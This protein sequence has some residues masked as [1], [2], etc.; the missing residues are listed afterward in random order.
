MYMMT[1]LEAK[2]EARQRAR[3]NPANLRLSREDRLKIWLKSLHPDAVDHIAVT[4]VSY[5]SARGAVSPRDKSVAAF[6]RSLYP[7]GGVLK[8]VPNANYE[9]CYVVLPNN[10]DA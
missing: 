1:R 10:A 3:N 8:R 6:A 9:A 7:Q 4:Q 2:R 5:R